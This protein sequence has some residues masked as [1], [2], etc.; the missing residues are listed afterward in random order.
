MPKF[1]SKQLDSCVAEERYSKAQIACAVIQV[2][3]DLLPGF[4]G[5]SAMPK[6]TPHEVAIK[7]KH[8]L[9]P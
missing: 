7:N 2:T 4:Q 1:F 5:F 8:A 6:Q 9:L 3:G